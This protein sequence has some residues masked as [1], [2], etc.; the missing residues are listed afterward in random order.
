MRV[1]IAGESFPLKRSHDITLRPDTYRIRL[2]S[3]DVFLDETRTVTVDSQDQL[4]LNLPP[5]VDLRVFAQP[6]NCR[7][8]VNE[9][10]LDETPFNTSVVPGSYEFRFEWR[11]QTRT[12]LQRI[13]RQTEQVF[14]SPD[15]QDQ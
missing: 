3:S 15:E 7:V 4:S 8:Y 14:G 9:K 11:D 1:E 5:A 2:M 10:Y 6:G 13:T 12:I